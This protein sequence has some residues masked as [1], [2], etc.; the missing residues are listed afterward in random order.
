MTRLVHMRGDVAG[1]FLLFLVGFLGLWQLLIAWRRLHGLSLTGCPDRRW[2]SAALGV[3]LVAGA[4]GWYFSRP[5]HFVYPDVEGAETVF[6]FALG[7]TAASL[8]QTAAGDPRR[9]LPVAG[10]QDHLFLPFPGILGEEV[11]L[12]AGGVRSP[13]PGGTRKRTTRGRPCCCC[14]TTA[15]AAATWLSL[16]GFLAARGH[17]VLAPT[18]TGTAPTRRG[19]TH[20]AWKDCSKPRWPGWRRGAAAS[21][22][23]VVG[24]GFGGTLALH[25]AAADVNI[26]RAVAL[27][28]PAQEESGTSCLNVLRECRVRD[29]LRAFF[30]PAARD[31]APGKRVSQAKLLGSVSPPAA[32]DAGRAVIVGTAGAWMNSPETL[33]GFAAGL[34]LAPPSI[35]PGRHS[36]LHLREEAFEAVE[37]SL[38]E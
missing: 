34:G 2:A 25:Q 6:L 36:T 30:R 14:T 5:N 13:R 32:L 29:I 28:P 19:S 37:R 38:R 27:D 15:A 22:I 1:L 31:T 3:A 33:K 17:A 10:A 23:A 12:E 35:V 8:L 11:T 20:R 18:S 4:C 9:P 16:G 21:G 24:L 26:V 7:L